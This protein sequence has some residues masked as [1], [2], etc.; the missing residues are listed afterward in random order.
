MSERQNHERSEGKAMGVEIRAAVVTVSDRCARGERED[1]SGALLVELLR[2]AGAT[3]VAREV[4]PDDLAP[5][6][7][8]LRALADRTDVNLVVTTGGTGLSPRD[9]P[10][11]ATPAGV[12]REV[13]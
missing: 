4:L 8:A 2:E 11:A 5:L 3:V 6:A 10:P 13:P 9:N 7:E 1:E 12:A